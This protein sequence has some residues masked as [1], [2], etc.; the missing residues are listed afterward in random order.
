MLRLCLIFHKRDSDKPEPSLRSIG[1]GFWYMLQK[2]TNVPQKA[3]VSRIKNF[4][5]KRGV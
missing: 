3:L 1:W 5:Q 2:M 4:E